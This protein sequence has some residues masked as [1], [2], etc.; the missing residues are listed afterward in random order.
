MYRLASIVLLLLAT[1]LSA[2]IPIKAQEGI[3]DSSATA[4]FGEAIQFQATLHTSQPIKY[5]LLYFQEHGDTRT[6]VKPVNISILDKASYQMDYSLDLNEQPMRVFT[7]IDYRFEVTLQ[8]GEVI[9]GPTK[10]LDYVDDRFPWQVKQ[11]ALFRVHWYQGD[12]TFAQKALDAAQSGL[13]RIR[14]ILPVQNPP[15]I[16]IYIYPNSTD[17]Q[18]TLQLAGQTWVAGHAD[19]DLG[20]IVV[21]IPAGPEQQLLLEQRIPHELLHVWLYQSLGANYTALPTWLSEGLASNAELL[22]N[23][24][25]Q[26]TLENAYQ[27]EKLVTMASLCNNFPR[28][29]SGAMLAYAQSTAFVSFIQQ[30]YGSERLQNL[31]NEYVDGVS[32]DS[33]VQN[34]LGVSLAHLE[35]QWRRAQ[36]GENPVTLAMSKLSPWLAVFGAVIL[37]PLILAFIWLR[38]RNLRAS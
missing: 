35:R 1:L 17:M 9:N 37:I 33:G 34:A 24:D 32:C 21:T 27:K 23:P 19:P 28:D 12:L 26:I 7:T 5:A 15:P 16:D 29:A 30:S 11:E 2:A 38:Q 3:F 22:P 31:L 36:F 10:S 8:N 6:E 25:Y 18:Q 13:E 4:R 14:S 20:V